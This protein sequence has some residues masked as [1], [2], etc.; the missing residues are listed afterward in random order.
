MEFLR[1]ACLKSAYALLL[2]VCIISYPLFSQSTDSIFIQAEKNYSSGNYKEAGDLYGQIP[3]QDKNYI[4]ALSGLGRS[5]YCC[6]VFTQGKDIMEKALSKE[7]ENIELRYY[8]AIM[9][10][11]IM[12]YGNTTGMKSMY[13]QEDCLKKARENILWI[14]KKDSFYKD[15]FYQ[16]SLFFRFRGDYEEALDMNIHQINLKP[17]EY[18]NYCGLRRNLCSAYK[19]YDKK[20]LEKY[21]L[22]DKS[23]I[24]EYLWGEYKRLSGEKEKSKEILEGLL[25]K[26][27]KIPRSLIY[28][29]L[30]RIYAEEYSAEKF[31]EIYYKCLE[32]IEKPVGIVIL[33]DDMKYLASIE[34]INEFKNIKDIKKSGNDIYIFWNKRN[35]S[36][37]LSMNPRILEHYKRLV[38]A[39]KNYS[40]DKERYSF[41][42]N[43]DSY[44]LNNEFTDQGYIYIHH[45]EPDDRSLTSYSKIEEGGGGG[46]GKD[47]RD[48]DDAMANNYHEFDSQES[49][50]SGGKLNHTGGMGY[51]LCESWLYKQTKNTDKMIFFFLGGEKQLSP[52]IFDRH[53]LE[54]IEG[55]D[56]K[57]SDYLFQTDEILNEFRCSSKLPQPKYKVR[58]QMRFEQGTKRDLTVNKIY[59]EG[60]KS[61]E[62]GKT[63][64]RSN[65]VKNIINLELSNDIYTF[66]GNNKKTELELA[67]IIPTAEI[68][69]KMPDTI[70][71]LKVEAGYGIYDK[72]W[73][74]MLVKT[75]TM[76]I[77]KPSK[78][79]DNY[80]KM[81]HLELD[82]DSA[83][84]S[85]FYHPLGTE[86]YGNFKKEKRIRDYST[87]G[88]NISDIMVTGKIE[89]TK[90]S[91]IFNK[92]GLKVIPLIAE[93]YAIEKPL[94]IYFEIYNLKKNSD[95]KTLYSI[96]YTMNYRGEDV[97][98]INS[99]LGKGKKSS[100]SVEYNM[101][102]SKEF[103]AEHISFEI[104]KLIPGKYSLEV[105]VK[106][107]NGR[108]TEKRIREIEVYENE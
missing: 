60:K 14:I 24:K 12:Y 36:P 51:T 10:R 70:K 72:N 69:K 7:P 104:N 55:W 44:I 53:I 21:L 3:E 1:F 76:N 67:F 45:G 59:S 47:V 20:K 57:I 15:I 83:G 79:N 54:N 27:P 93:S 90:E 86:I 30:F 71:T 2:A 58:A 13:M 98:I 63:E 9:N 5:L 26:N 22:N 75:D 84:I 68:F 106:D 16:Y 101:G 35:P 28:L 11:D 78:E 64:E 99:L 31:E 43:K 52:I 92:K 91:G 19:N 105:T 66:R 88:L 23:A 37:L 34:E 103:S 18:S 62:T 32:E 82:P 48:R 81:L 49:M 89:N 6:N 100:I 61:I 38:Y 29:S 97:N 74:I 87:N 42:V 39:E 102:G 41:V 46:N 4:S 56:K 108:K 96:E 50:L 94:N 85:L 77:R 40:Y 25:N 73:N 107:I 8:T 17:E 80:L 33:F 65:W 95:G